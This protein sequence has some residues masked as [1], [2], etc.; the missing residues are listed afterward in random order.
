M[1]LVSAT[2]VYGF[3]LAEF[4]QKAAVAM[5]RKPSTVDFESW[6]ANRDGFGAFMRLLATDLA[7]E[8]VRFEKDRPVEHQLR[9]FDRRK[10]LTFRLE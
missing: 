6:V 10:T 1:V 7:P 2:P 9:T 8:W 3:E 4:A 5:G